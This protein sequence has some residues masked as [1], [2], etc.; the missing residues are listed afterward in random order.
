MEEACKLDEDCCH[1][2]SH[3]GECR[4]DHLVEDVGDH[5]GGAHDHRVGEREDEDSGG[6]GP[7]ESRLQS[8]LL[9][10]Q[11]YAVWRVS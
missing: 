6:G 9:L 2:W 10:V 5:E 11:R 7:P 1:T 4:D 8:P 3:N